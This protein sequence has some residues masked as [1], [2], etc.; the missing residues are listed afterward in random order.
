[1]LLILPTLLRIL[2][3]GVPCILMCTAPYGT[4][5]RICIVQ[6]SV[7]NNN[8]YHLIE[9]SSA[10]RSLVFHSISKPPIFLRNAPMVNSQHATRIGSKC[11]H[12]LSTAGVD[13]CREYAFF[14]G[15]SA[16]WGKLNMIYDFG[17]QAARLKCENIDNYG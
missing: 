9:L 10:G 14:H 6:T 8:I 1:M 2:A 15:C 3:K 11:C 12:A 5:F 4:A 17:I 13:D 16:T 7:G